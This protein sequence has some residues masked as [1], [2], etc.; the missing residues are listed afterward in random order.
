MYA[1]DTWTNLAMTEGRRDTFEDFLKNVEPLKDII[2]PLKGLSLE[3]AKEFKHPIDIL[4]IDGD[5]SYENV[6]SD[7]EVWLPKLKTKGILI[8]HDYGW[9]EGVKRMVEEYVKPIEISKGHVMG[10]T[11]WARVDP[12]RS[13]R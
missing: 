8:L 3:I 10:N 5:H 4:F 13:K 1:V 9:A 2:T 11:Y 6:R 7:I 12:S